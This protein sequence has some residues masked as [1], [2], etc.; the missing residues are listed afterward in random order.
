DALGQRIVEL[1][2]G[3]GFAVLVTPGHGAETDDANL[4]AA[5][6]EWAVFHGCVSRNGGC[7]RRAGATR[8]PG[9][10]GL[11]PPYE[12]VIVQAVTAWLVR[13]Y[14][15]RGCGK[16]RWS[17]KVLPAYSWRKTPRLRSSGTTSST[18]TSTPEGNMSGMMLKPS[19]APARNH[20][21]RLSAT[22][23]GV[24]TISRWPTRM[25]RDSS[26]TLIFS[27]RAR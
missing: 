6:A 9:G 7:L 18:N 27:R 1:L 8:Q 23:S 24:P 4:D 22:C 25:R 16:P 14:W 12:F 15:L 10:G 19:A 20:C 26:R 21:S 3:V 13:S 5:V 17:R 2:V 11:H